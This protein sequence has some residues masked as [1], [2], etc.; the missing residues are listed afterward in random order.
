LGII[1]EYQDL[2]VIHFLVSRPTVP[3]CSWLCCV[4]V[5][6]GF[7]IWLRMLFQRPN[8]PSSHVGDCLCNME[9]HVPSRCDL[10]LGINFAAH[11]PLHF[12]NPLSISN[13]CPE[14]W[15]FRDLLFS[16]LCQ[17]GYSLLSLSDTIS[18]SFHYFLLFDKMAPRR[19]LTKEEQRLSAH[20][21]KHAPRQT[22]LPLA[23][24]P[25]P[26][27][28]PGR[29]P[30][31]SNVIAGRFGHSSTETEDV[32]FGTQP[33]EQYEIVGKNYVMA[34]VAQEINSYLERTTAEGRKLTYH[35]E[36][37]QKPQRARA[38]GNGPR[39]KLCSTNDKIRHLT[40][41]S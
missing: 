23:P 9:P 26:H 22:P 35:L 16:C 14:A 20:A 30:S 41:I 36:V 13:I 5:L 24:R 1:L 10:V 27:T 3:I 19:R 8:A 33:L 21:N 7:S 39:C 12:L 18:L 37:V 31:L 38:C 29:L 32:Y 2:R 4:S 28:I 34:R 6:S 15:S 11:R 40:N 25:A 17:L